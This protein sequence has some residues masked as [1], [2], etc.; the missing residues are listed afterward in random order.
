MPAKQTA[1][2]MST[3]RVKPGSRCH[4]GCRSGIRLVF[5]LVTDKLAWRF[6]VKVL[7]NMPVHSDSANL[8]GD[9]GIFS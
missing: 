4:L 2:C 3:A 6:D 8:P 7:N 9:S 5:D 1:G